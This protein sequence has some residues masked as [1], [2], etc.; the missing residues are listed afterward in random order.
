MSVRDSVSRRCSAASAVGEQVGEREARV[1]VLRVRVEQVAQPALGALAIAGLGLGGRARDRGGG[2]DVV[3]LRAQILV[4]HEVGR[5]LVRDDRRAVIARVAKPARGLDQQRGLVGTGG[6]RVRVPQ[7]RGRVRERIRIVLCLPD[8]ALER[9]DIVGGV[10]QQLAEHDRGGVAIAARVLEDRRVARA[11]RGDVLARRAALDRLDHARREHVGR[12]APAPAAREHIG[13]VDE[14]ADV[15]GRVAGRPRDRLLGAAH[16]ARR[17]ERARLRAERRRLLDLAGRAVREHAADLGELLPATE[18]REDVVERLPGVAIARAPVDDRAIDLGR[19]VELGGV[20]VEAGGGVHRRARAIVLRARRDALEHLGCLRERAGAPVQ[21]R[22]AV[23][24]ID[25]VGIERDDRLHRGDR[26]ERL[27]EV[28]VDVGELFPERRGDLA[29][30]CGAGLVGEKHR[31]LLAA[32]GVDRERAQ[33]AARLEVVRRA[34]DL[35]D[36][37]AHRVERIDLHVDVG[38]RDPLPA[39]GRVRHAWILR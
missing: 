35:R 26:L 24:V 18:L 34:A 32:G 20:A 39:S 29:R 5:G 23:E 37:G 14:P 8:Q 27:V 1:D 16:V 6:E 4:G 19:A 13:V 36:R 11:Q 33:L 30:V 2:A 10:G 25:V 31:E 28:L 3:E 21:P 38:A 12:L 22:E 9:G 15:L 17:L 7:Q